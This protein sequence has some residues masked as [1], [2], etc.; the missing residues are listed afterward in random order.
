M[1]D[2]KFWILFSAIVIMLFLYMVFAA[3]QQ[4]RDCKGEL[5]RNSQGTVCVVT[6]KPAQST[7]SEQQ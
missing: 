3:Y 7:Q 2:S 5:I 6:I 1:S 4:E